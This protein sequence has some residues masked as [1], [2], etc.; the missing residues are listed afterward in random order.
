M[1]VL[2]STWLR[3]RSKPFSHDCPRRAAGEP[4]RGD[5]TA[6]PASDSF[7][8]NG[9]MRKRIVGSSRVGERPQTR[10]GW[11][12]LEQIATI[13]VTSEEPNFP[14]ESAFS[15]GDGTGWRACDKGVQEIRIIFDQP[16]TL[17]RIQLHFLEAEL[18]RTQEFSI[19]WSSAEGGPTKE[20]IR[21]QWNFSP[22]G[23]T[24]EVE[25][26]EVSLD[27]VAVLELSIVPDLATREATAT[28]AKWRV[29]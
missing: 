1:E 7:G 26:Y 5:R 3:L 28:L 6:R 18:E 25:D 15:S 2:A 29:A 19:R 13:E 21:Q 22:S 14:I 23:S 10:E 17:R 16:I 11:L 8:D 24:R 20:I 9:S 4:E 12:D 27:N